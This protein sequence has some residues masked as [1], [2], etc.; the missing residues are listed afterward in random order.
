MISTE[1][2][3]EIL[4]KWRHGKQRWRRKAYVSTCQQGD[5]KDHGILPQSGPSEKNLERSLWRLTGVGKMLHLVDAF[6]GSIR[7]AAESKAWP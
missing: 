5:D 3:A 7:N 4:I 2:M 1:P 6:P